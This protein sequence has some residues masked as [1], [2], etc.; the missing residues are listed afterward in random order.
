MVGG[1]DISNLVNTKVA[2]FIEY[3][4]HKASNHLLSL[5]DTKIDKQTKEYFS[6]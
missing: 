4:P 5:K 2:K 3:Q 1:L 6:N